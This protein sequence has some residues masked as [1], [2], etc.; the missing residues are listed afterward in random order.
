MA[1]ETTAGQRWMS[2]KAW[3][4][5][6]TLPC[7]RG[8]GRVLGS[9]ACQWQWVAHQPP[10]PVGQLPAWQPHT[11][12]STS[13]PAVMHG[14]GRKKASCASPYKKRERCWEF[15]GS[16]VCSWEQQMAA[17]ARGGEWC[18][19]QALLLSLT[20]YQLCPWLSQQAMQ[21]LPPPPQQTMQGM[22]HALWYHTVK[23][24]LWRVQSSPPI[25]CVDFRASQ[26]LCPKDTVGMC[27][28]P[29]R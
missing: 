10:G 28:D 4:Q 9:S 23:V 15:K 6:G 27:C 16:Q 20:N 24:L 7:E 19:L 12:G 29:K 8:G 25:A 22:L 17:K 2:G 26:Q 5:E 18:P 13:W 11:C 21:P 1:G 3:R 14:L